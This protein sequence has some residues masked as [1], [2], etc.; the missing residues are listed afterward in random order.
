MDCERSDKFDVQTG[1]AS[2]KVD[3][4]YDNDFKCPIT[5][6]YVVLRYVNGQM[7]CADKNCRFLA[8]LTMTIPSAVFE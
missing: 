8:D 2:E 7:W 1:D 4:V 6:A 5:G 3:D